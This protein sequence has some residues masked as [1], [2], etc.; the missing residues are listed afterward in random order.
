MANTKSK[1]ST[2]GKTSST[3]R[4]STAPKRKAGPA[5]KS[6]KAK[7][8]ARSAAAAP[9]KNGNFLIEILLVLVFGAAILMMVSNIGKG[10]PIGNVISTYLFGTMGKMAF[11]F[12][13]ILI[14]VTLFA[15]INKNSK[16]LKK[17]IFAFCSCS[18]LSVV[19]CRLDGK[20]IKRAQHSLNIFTEALRLETA[21]VFWAVWYVSPQY[22]HSE[23]SA[24]M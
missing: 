12:P 7:A 8:S 9:E 19:F 2:T 11:A 21:A 4:K 1:R 15:V 16:R 6:S 23:E 3:A 17:K 10:G 24:V 13:F 5:G 22:P 20:G 14:L 18:L